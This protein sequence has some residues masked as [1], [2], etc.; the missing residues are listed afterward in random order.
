MIE[1]SGWN[2]AAIII[3]V[4]LVIY[5]PLTWYYEHQLEKQAEEIDALTAQV[6]TTPV[7]NPDAVLDT[8]RVYQAVVNT[9]KDRSLAGKARRNLRKANQRAERAALDSFRPD[10]VTEDDEHFG[11]YADFGLRKDGA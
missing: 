6:S 3:A 10:V 1:L 2:L 9:D 8:S 5:V 11:S 7:F 4:A